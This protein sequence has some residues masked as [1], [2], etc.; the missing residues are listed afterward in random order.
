MN[1]KQAKI[2]VS[3]TF[4]PK[5]LDRLDTLRAE[6]RPIPSRSKMVRD[7]VKLHLDQQG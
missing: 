5:I 7:I 3:M 1:E 6:H 4:D 2:V